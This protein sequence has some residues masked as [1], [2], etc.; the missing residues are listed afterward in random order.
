M[1]KIVVLLFVVNFS[2]AQQ[3]KRKL[4]WEENFNSK[5]LNEKSWNIKPSDIDK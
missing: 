1:K 5:T 4:V 3:V 2:F